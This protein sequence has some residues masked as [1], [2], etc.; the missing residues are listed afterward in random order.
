MFIEV[1]F[2]C[3]NSID[4]FSRVVVVLFRFVSIVFRKL[5]WYF[6]CVVMVVDMNICSSCR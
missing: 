5:V 6:S 3:R 1:V 4:S 2:G